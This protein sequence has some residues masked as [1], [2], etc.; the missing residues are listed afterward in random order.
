[1][2]FHQ[3]LERG[4]QVPLSSHQAVYYHFGDHK[5][6]LDALSR[7][8]DSVRETPVTNIVL[9][10]QV[11]GNEVKII[12]PSDLTQQ[13][14]VV[15]HVDGLVTKQ[16]NVLLCIKTADCVPV[17]LYDAHAEVIGAVHA[18]RDGT[19]QNI[20]AEAVKNMRILG[21]ESQRIYALLGPA[22]CS[23]HYPVNDELFWQF[24]KDTGQTQRHPWL[25]MKKVLIAQLVEAGVCVDRIHNDATCT[26]ESDNY[27]SYRKNGDKG[28][29]I[30]WIYRG[31]PC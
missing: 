18:G 11:H 8:Q 21:A 27:F 29:Q 31:L 24:V 30:S 19:R 14:I 15:P 4:T 3:I 7:C 23:K 9:G 28:R 5:Y 1:M 12:N 22:I 26:W 25:D 20:I 2:K 17:L 16:R 13:M 10:E 6:S